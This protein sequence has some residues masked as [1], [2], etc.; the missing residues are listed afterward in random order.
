MMLSFYDFQGLFIGIWIGLFYD[1]ATAIYILAV[2][3]FNSKKAE[4]P[5]YKRP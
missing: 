5:A 4:K 3:V 2:F 1:L